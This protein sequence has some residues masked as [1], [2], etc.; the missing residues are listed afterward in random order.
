MKQCLQQAESAPI[1]QGFMSAARVK[2]FSVPSA[3]LRFTHKILDG[4]AGSTAALEATG[5]KI[6][7]ERK[8]DP[9]G[10]K[11]CEENS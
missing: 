10:G 8:P 9:A 2:Q 1:G 6:Y 5:A 3:G 11:G 4:I 7:P